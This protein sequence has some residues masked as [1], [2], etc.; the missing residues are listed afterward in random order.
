MSAQQ[1]YIH[2]ILMTNIQFVYHN[3]LYVYNQGGT[4]PMIR[5]TA[6]YLYAAENRTVWCRYMSVQMIIKA[7][8]C[9]LQPWNINPLVLER[10]IKKTK[11]LALYLLYN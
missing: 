6:C 3:M 1:K 10:V 4:E 5:G 2:K 11:L 7:H 9:K 8:G